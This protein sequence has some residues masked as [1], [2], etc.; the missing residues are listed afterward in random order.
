V[1]PR[2]GIDA[3]PKVTVEPAGEKFLGMGAV[4]EPEAVQPAAIVKPAVWIHPIQCREFDPAIDTPSVAVRI[5][6]S[7]LPERGA[8]F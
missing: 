7:G 5:W 3:A 6:I 4:A 1:E 2:T 8:L